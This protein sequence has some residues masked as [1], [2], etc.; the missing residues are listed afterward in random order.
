MKAVKECKRVGVV[1]GAVAIVVAILLMMGPDVPDPQHQNK[2]LSAW[3]KDLRSGRSETQA[4]AEEAITN[5]GT[6]ALPMLLRE[7]RAQDP[8]G[9]QVWYRILSRKA[10]TV[11][12]DRIVSADRALRILGP[13]A[14]G[15]LPALLETAGDPRCGDHRPRAALV[16]IGPAAVKPMISALTNSNARIR[17]CAALVLT[18]LG[19]SAREAAPALLRSLG[20]PDGRV[21]AHAAGA[22]SRIGAEPEVA[23]SALIER[24]SDSD[25]YVRLCAT[26]ALGE[27]GERAGLAVPALRRLEADESPEVRQ[28]A[29]ETL[30]RV[31]RPG[32]SN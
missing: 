8:L 27:F 2:P 10:F 25:L 1:L 19:P 29:V 11:A 22:L 28:Q 14:E 30:R 7:L 32:V 20:D 12:A 31:E 24:L 18:G 9:W 17:S 21:R 15:A 26:M 16:A 4:R 5:I 13:K 23:V 6:N 3:L